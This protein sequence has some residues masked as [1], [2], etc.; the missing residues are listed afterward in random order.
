[1]PP[2]PAWFNNLF[3]FEEEGSFAANRE[4]FR[5]DGDDLVC[6]SAPQFKRQIVGKFEVPSVGEL[7]SRCAELAA[8]S[9]TGLKFSHLAASDGVQPLILDPAN[10]GAVF[11]AASQFNCLEMTGPAVTPA[12]GIAIYFNDPTQG[13]KC[14]LACPA[15]TVYRNYLCQDGAG[16]G[17]AQI[18]CL[19]DVAA[20]VNNE[21]HRY[22]IMKN[23][24]A[25]PGSVKAMAQ[26]GKRITEDA[27]L[28]AVALGGLRV[29]VHWA[30][31]A[32][33]PCTH[34]VA[35]VYA[36]ALPVAY[37]QNTKPEDF[38]PFARVILRGAYE[39]TL[40]VGTLHAATRPSGRATVYLT[41]LG[42]G[43]FGNAL[44][45]IVDAMAG[46]MEAYKEAP[47]DVILVHYGSQVP[48]PW[49]EALPAR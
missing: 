47:L 16:Q 45:W 17:E 27:S 33:P 23:G 36:S 25:L 41:C 9:S 28:A 13:P 46:A 8:S 19:V 10:E 20:A 29:G 37:A 30:T 18:D 14:A 2:K 31:Q 34:L 26:L 21:K 4:K 1:M 7:R 12:R 15:G 22:W 5:M 48:Q 6:D 32:A 38:E 40:A 35:Q 3:G 42:G 49:A 11:Q 24:Y 44:E 39:A 43:A